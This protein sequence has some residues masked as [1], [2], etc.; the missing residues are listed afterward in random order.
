MRYLLGFLSLRYWLRHRGGLLLSMLGV[1]MG[2]A[3]FVSVQI[4]NH[5]VLAAFESS[6]EAVAGR[7]NLQI[8]GGASGLPEQV[9]TDLKVHPDAR[10]QAAAPLLSKTLFSPTL[11]L[12]PTQQTN[13]KTSAD[14]GTN[15]LLLGI[16]LSAEADFL[17]LDWQTQATQSILEGAE[18]PNSPRGT[19]KK[20]V[21]STSMPD[22]QAASNAFR[23]L[24]DPRAIAI[25]GAMAKRYDLRIGSAIDFFVGATKQRFKVAAILRDANLNRAFGG[26]FALLDIAAAQESWHEIGRLSGI[27]LIVDEAQLAAVRADL[28]HRLP[29]DATVARPAQ[30]GAQ[31]ADLLAAFQLNLAA[32]SCI[33]LFVGAFLIYN[34]IA[35]A[36]VRRRNEVG[37]LRAVGTPQNQLLRLFLIEAAVIGLLGSLS[38]L[39]I[40]I[41]LARFTLHEV[42]RTVSTLYVAVKAR[43][44]VVPSWLWWGAP[45]GGTLL[46]TLASWPAAREAAG[47]SPRAALSRSN[48]S[49]HQATASWAKPLAKLGVA[50]ILFSLA[51]CHPIISARAFWI[52]FIATGGTLGGFALLAPLLAL[53]SG[54]WVQNAGSKGFG[55]ETMLAGSYLQ[56]AL[57]R[58]SLV[59][60]ALMVS[61][62]MTIGLATMVRSFR[63]TVGDWV[64]NTISADLFVAPARGFGEESGPGLPAEVVRFAREFPGVRA[65]DSIRGAETTFHNQPI[66]IAANTLPSLPLGLRRIRFVATRNGEAQAL[67]D[68]RSGRAILVSERFANLLHFRAGESVSIPTPRG[69]KYFAIAGV[70]YDYTPNECVLYL[71]QSTYARLWNDRATDG[72]ALYLPSGTL[73]EAAKRAFEQRFGARFALTLLPNREIRQS[74]FK[75]FDDTFAVTYA[76][77][78]IAVIVAAIGIFDT[79]L[80]L[81]LERGRE[82]ATL[83][84]TGASASQIV[85]VTLIEFALVGFLSWLL[86]CGAGTVLACELIFVINRQFFGWT[87]VPSLP[88]SILGQALFLSLAASLGAGIWPSIA[89]ARAAIAPALQTE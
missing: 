85:R 83:R 52:G 74:V 35:V 63:D 20:G 77:Q 7:A 33:T 8:R 57:N 34:T 14:A 31:V 10:I 56:R 32:L 54:R 87:I 28:Q 48:V 21:Q 5:S 79:L 68:Y 78:L 81:V 67:A 4:A 69:L 47:T 2:V 24:L 23:F 3:V 70:F 75:T 39:A 84:A 11:K 58:S 45:L 50:L 82:L 30:R 86:A 22:N 60:A 49:L 42:S 27:D 17:D 64:N 65:V 53:H 29:A 89:A 1:A 76:L 43:D 73:G 59:I 25:S 61:L 36:V 19:T 72:L 15:V 40:G 51:L 46:S 13:S 41:V 66:F 12:H 62:A 55:V 6:L 44:I 38:G 9:Y 26:D 18:S 88:I 37:T 80:A 71:A 16:D